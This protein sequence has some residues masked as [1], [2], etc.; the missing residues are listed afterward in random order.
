M[1]DFQT[2]NNQESIQIMVAEDQLSASVWIQQGESH[3]TAALLK[4]RLSE[5]GVTSGLQEETIQ[6]LA[7]GLL[8]D[9]WVVVAKGTP[10]VN[11]EDGWYEYAFHRETDHKPKILEDGSVDY[12]QYGNIPSVE[13]GDVIAVYHPATEAKDG[14]DVHGNIL[15]ARKGKNLARLVGKGFA[16]AEDGCTYI[17]NRSG[18][19]VETMDKIF[20]DQEFVVEGDLTNSTGSICFRGDIRIRGNVGSGVSVVSEKGSILV[21]GFVEGADLQANR[22]ITL[23]NGMQG[24][25]KGFIRAKGN[26]NAK[27]FEQCTICADGCVNANAIMNCQIEAGEDV[28]VSGRFGSIIGGHISAQRQIKATNIGNV[29]EVE[30]QVEAGVAEN[31]VTKMNLLT[32]SKKKALDEWERIAQGIERIDTLMEQTKNA[33]L[34]E[35]KRVLMRGKIEKDAEISELEKKIQATV[36]AMEKANVAKVTVDRYVHPGTCISVNGMK[37]QVQELEQHVE[38]ARRGNGIIV[39]H[40]DEA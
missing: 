35:K 1:T 28:V 18:K 12:S 7:N 29:A 5:A 14:M 8:Y 6:Q 20:I 3:Y 31:L 15:V 33:A 39:Y 17:A 13:E 36:L 23:K 2:E 22:D 27:F 11:G 9:Q 34:M 30:N 19:I 38:Y 16:C 25:G 21:D 26:V 4:N 10:Y 24:N 32:E 40:I 37:T